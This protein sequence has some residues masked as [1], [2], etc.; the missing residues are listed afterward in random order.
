MF[1]NRK[2][3]GTRWL[4]ALF[5]LLCAIAIPLVVAA[6]GEGGGSYEPPLYGTF[7]S[8][9]PP[10]VAIILALITKEVFSSLFF[11]V[12]IGGVLWAGG[13]NPA[14]YDDA[15]EVVWQSGNIFM[16]TLNHIIHDG[17]LAQLTD[18]WNIGI[19]I[20]LAVL[21]MIV[22]MMA[23]VGGS[24][25]FGAWAGKRVK[26]RTG[27]ILSLMLFHLFIF[28]DDYFACLTVGNVMRPVTD[29][30][31]ISRAKLAYCIDAT[32]APICIL[33][34]IST[35]AAAVASYVP[36]DYA[37]DIDGLQMFILAIP[38]N[39]YA[40]LTVVMVLSLA[41]LKF[42][43]G[44]MATHEL[45]AATNG[46]LYTT[47]DRPYAN[48]EEKAVDEKGKVVDL[49]AP[50]LVL[51]VACVLGMIYTGGFFD[52]GAA[53]DGYMDFRL[54]FSNADAAVGLVTGCLVA[55]V[56]TI[57]YYLVRRLLSLRDLTKLVPD[58]LNAMGSPILI[59]TFAWTLKA[60]TDSLGSSQFVSE[61]MQGP[62]Q[63]LE[64]I[65]PAIV[66]LVAVFIAFST[67]T[68]WGT[69]GILIPIVVTV[70]GNSEPT[71]LIIGVAAC[72]AG[73]VCGDHCSPISDTTIMASAGAQCNH[74]NHVNTQLP[75]AATV[76]AFSF[77]MYIIAGF[78]RSVVILPIAVVLFIGLMFV[79]RKFFGKSVPVSVG[80]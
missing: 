7:W 25:A 16:G 46:D 28:I 33:A 40:I 52:S 71:L 10:L 36:D 38:F 6:Q 73:G 61:A 8:L 55:I 29:K 47:P 66:F 63:S 4:A 69:Y 30:V 39:F 32:A 54:A 45:N 53:G 18:G 35:W 13:A 1:S 68:S 76:A 27:G 78:M 44:P 37:G 59:L 14:V 5:V 49:I 26:T 15:G 9:F 21:G 43:Y 48:A 11:G 56:V 24:A 22:V 60:M 17:F 62:A 34:P 65:L 41:L 50:I 58:G 23:H 72:L 67:G 31:R 74:I 42:D 64:S 79:V 70:F 51:I 80:R 75:Y 20:F 77:V 2:V 12:L 19:I 3:S 57:L